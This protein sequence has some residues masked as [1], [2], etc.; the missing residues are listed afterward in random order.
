MNENLQNER[1]IFTRTDS[2]I[3]ADKLILQNQFFS[4][5]K[6]AEE[7]RR[8]NMVYQQQVAEQSKVLMND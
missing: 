8:K 2:A 1:K 6:Q 4:L 5:E 7:I 3:S